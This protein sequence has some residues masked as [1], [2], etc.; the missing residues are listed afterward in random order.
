VPTDYFDRLATLKAHIADE[1]SLQAATEAEITEVLLA[2]H[3]FYEQLRFVKGGEPALGPAFWRENG[4]DHKRVVASLSHLLFGPGDFIQRLHD[5]LYEPRWG[6]AS[7]AFP[8]ISRH[9]RLD[10]PSV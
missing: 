10:S 8:A 3:A 7:D 4:G 5:L 9:F 1:A 6:C 2:L